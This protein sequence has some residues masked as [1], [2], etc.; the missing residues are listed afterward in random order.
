MKTIRFCFGL[1]LLVAASIAVAQESPSGDTTLVELLKKIDTQA[2]PDSYVGKNHQKWVDTRMAKLTEAQRDLHGRLWEAK[3]RMNPNQNVGQSFVKILHYISRGEKLGRILTGDGYGQPQYSRPFVQ[4]QGIKPGSKTRIHGRVTNAKGDPIEG[5][6]VTAYNEE[7]EVSASVF[8]GVDGKFELNK[9]RKTTHQMRIRQPG[10]L[11][12]RVMDVEPDSD[13]LAVTM[14]PAAGEKLQM[15][16]TAASAMSLMKWDSLRDKENFKMMCTYCHQ[17]GTV[18]FRT[19]EQPVDWETMVRRMDGFGGLYKH[20][21]RTI[22]KRLMDTYT[23]DAESRWPEYIPPSPPTGFAAKVKITEWDIGIPLKANV[24]DLEPGPPGTMYAVDMGQGAIVEL[25]IPTGQ[26]TVFRMPPGARAP[27]S[28]EPDN[29]GNYWV[30]LCASGHMGKFDPKTTDITIWSSAEAPAKNGSYPHTLRVNPKDP[31]G[32]IW[33]TDAGR[34]SVFYI[35]PRTGFVK[36][37]HLLEK[38]IYQ[39]QRWSY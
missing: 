14:K 15:Q 23:R 16:R 33:Y 36:E 21:Q 19:P 8:T 17:A 31:E 26:R 37:Y 3:R 38:K 39:K 6:M 10:K 20:T 2:M 22:I 13:A 25:D 11:D 28:I 29:D 24:H 5:V 27:H 12:V 1:A 35:H 18:G 7:L 4:L 9:L 34:N 32:L 30:T